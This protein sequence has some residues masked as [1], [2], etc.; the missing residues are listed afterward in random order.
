LQASELSLQ[1]EQENTQKSF[2]TCQVLQTLQKKD[3]TQRNQV[4]SAK[5]DFWLLK[6][7]KLV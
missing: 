2:G 3:H 7:F 1:Q 5:A 4:K 6:R